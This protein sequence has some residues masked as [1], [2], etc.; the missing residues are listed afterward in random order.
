MK[1]ISRK[2][3]ENEK[4]IWDS[5][6]KKQNYNQIV[7]YLDVGFRY[8]DELYFKSDWL[9]ETKKISWGTITNLNQPRN[10]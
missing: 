5:I 10:L 1:K 2:V 9:I 8:R 3:S 6:G 7:L 4:A